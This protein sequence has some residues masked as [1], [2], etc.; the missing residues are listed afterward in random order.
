MLTLGLSPGMAWAITEK[1]PTPALLREGYTNCSS[2]EERECL[3]TGM[4]YDGTKKLPKAVSK[5][6]SW[7]YNDSHLN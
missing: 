1:Y 5:A 4:V 7:L 6:V 3:L 2:D